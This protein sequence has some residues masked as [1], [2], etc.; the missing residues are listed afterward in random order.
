[1]NIDAVDRL[2]RAHRRADQDA[3]PDH[4]EAPEQ[5]QPVGRARA[6]TT[7]SRIRQ[8]IDQ[9]GQ[10]HHHD[11]DAGVD[12]AGDAAP[13]Q[14]RGRVDRQ[15]PHPVDDAL[16]D[17][18]G[19]A[20]RDDERRERDRLAHDPG[21]QP[22]AVA[23]VDA[24]DRDRAAEDERE[25]QHEHHRL[26]GDVQQHLGHPLDVD[27]VAPDDRQ[28]LA[29]AGA[30]APDLRALDA[31][32]R[33]G[34][35]APR[36]SRVQLRWIVVGSASSARWP[37]RCRN[38][39]SRLGRL[40]P[41]VVELDA[42]AV[43]DA[44]DPGHVAEPVGRGGELPGAL[45]D[46]DLGDAARAA[47]ARRGGRSSACETVTT[48]A[49]APDWSLSWSGVPCGDDAAL[50]DDDD[51]VGE[52]VGL[53]EVLRGQQQR[54]AVADQLAQHLPQL[55]AAARVEAGGRLVEEQ[56]RRRRDQAD[57]EVEPA[58]HA[59]GVGLDDPVRRRR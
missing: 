9:A 43:E 56:H 5:Q 16:V 21:Q 41:E 12:Q 26:D 2:D 7:P 55:D 48:S 58:P 51:V 36:R 38:T 33:R 19:E 31:R 46:V 20:D 45:V 15:R 4:R 29:R 40:Q 53:L 49:A 50:V 14:D 1:M 10:R 47:A 6:S 27:Q 34:R 42:A 52:L 59:A 37:V 25:Q 44:G 24:R 32:G 11:A 57:R 54:R 39:S 13:D 22:L 30:V 28:R 35:G 18:G 3:D 23:A 8:P 17:V